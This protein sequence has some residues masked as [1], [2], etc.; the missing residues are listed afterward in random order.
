[1]VIC[2]TQRLVLRRFT[3]EDLEALAT[4]QADD[5]VMRFFGGPRSKVEVARGLERLLAHYQRFDFGKWAVV[6][7]DSGALIGRCGPSVEAIEGREEVE[8][9]YLLAR[10]HWGQGLASEATRAALDHCRGQLALRRLVSIVDPLNQ[11]SHAVAQRIGMRRERSIRWRQR[12]MD[13]Y[14][15]DLSPA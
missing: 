1:V 9:G 11:P 4:I 15:L 7:R 10:R 3:P 6:L 12:T 5:E 13:L 14:T 2:Q 8:L